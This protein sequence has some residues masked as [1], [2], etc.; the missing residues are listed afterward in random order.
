[1][2]FSSSLIELKL[3]LEISFVYFSRLNRFDFCC[4]KNNFKNIKTQENISLN[5]VLCIVF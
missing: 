3:N 5:K 2:R 4:H 1:M